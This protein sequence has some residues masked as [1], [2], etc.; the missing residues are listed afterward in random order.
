M[1]NIITRKS[2]CVKT[3]GLY[4]PR[5]ILSVACPVG[6]GG[7]GYPVLPLSRMGGRRAGQGGVGVSR[8]SSG[9]GGGDRV[10]EAGGTLCGSGLGAGGGGAGDRAGEVGYTFALS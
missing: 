2:S 3:Q 8:P 1:Q 6:E 7:S 9:R 4:R 5:R 10:G